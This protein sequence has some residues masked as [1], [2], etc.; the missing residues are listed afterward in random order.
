MPLRF[1][2]LSLLRHPHRSRVA[3]DGQPSRWAHFWTKPFVLQTCS[4]QR[5]AGL[6]KSKLKSSY[7]QHAGLRRPRRH[8]MRFAQLEENLSPA[9]A[10]APTWPSFRGD[11]PLNNLNT[12]PNSLRPHPSALSP[13]CPVGCRLLRDLP[14]CSVPR[15]CTP[16]PGVKAQAHRRRGTAPQLLSTP[17]LGLHTGGAVTLAPAMS[18]VHVPKARGPSQQAHPCFGNWVTN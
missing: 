6:P 15:G 10:P 3:R 14:A 12:T 16:A 8:G 18:P 9:P 5:V 7:E 4:E 11:E 17:G 2:S 1:G 13:S